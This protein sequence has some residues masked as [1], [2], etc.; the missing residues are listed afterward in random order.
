MRVENRGR[1]PGGNTKIF[2]E[3]LEVKDVKLGMPKLDR[4]YGKRE[5]H[6]KG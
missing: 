1:I 3:I 6:K 5:I 4:Y 2:K